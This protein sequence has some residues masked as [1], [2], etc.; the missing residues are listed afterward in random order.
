[1]NEIEPTAVSIKR[2]ALQSTTTETG[3]TNPFRSV[4]TGALDRHN[5]VKEQQTSASQL[6]LVGTISEATPTVSELLINH[7]T[8]ADNTWNII[9]SKQN[10]G[11]D[12][13]NIQPGTHIY[14]DQHTGALSW[15]SESNYIA[16]MK[17]PHR[18]VVSSD[19]GVKQSISD[20]IPTPPPESNSTK[21]SDRSGSIGS[22]SSHPGHRKSDTMIRLGRISP[23]T[24][25]VS[26]VLTTH[27][28]LK[29]ITWQLLNNE[30]NKN[31][32]FHRI[33]SGTDIYVDA[34]SLEISWENTS[35]S[36]VGS[37]K[38][39]STKSEGV[40]ISSTVEKKP[41]HTTQ[42]LS[43]AV[44]GYL[45]TPYDQINCYELLVKGL[46][47]LDI[48]Y[49]GKNGL[50]AQL[51]QMALDRGMA[52][53]A[54]LNGEGI[55]E[56]AGSLVLS[57]NYALLKNWENEAAA[58][59]N[60]I[61]PLLDHGQILSFSTERR[62]HTG[63]VSTH[64]NEWT[65]INSGRLDNSIEPG[66]LSKGVGEE[67]LEEELRNWFKVAHE[68]GETLSVTLG[69][70]NQHKIQTASAGEPSFSKRI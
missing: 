1:M 38:P 20:K 9:H 16:S 6:L 26:H 54:F 46:K 42:N 40:P 12:Y 18:R 52:P 66:R 65:F 43:E 67:L 24:P 4:L 8:L 62:G 56:A 58:L 28:Q 61:E 21:R 14:F 47:Q 57:K 5:G 37:Q 63:I 64:N 15:S 33:A 51:T 32:P 22:P 34:A 25:T 59:I 36:V 41:S 31:K 44:K 29:E 7:K 70:L 35:T 30:V 48:P 69:N 19:P 45:G 11:K 68:S 60:E 49:S 27:P 13:T 10:L 50:F 3:A 23:A 39:P 2:A 53:N 55:I 17:E